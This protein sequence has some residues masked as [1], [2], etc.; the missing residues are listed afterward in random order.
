MHF[1]GL[2][3]KDSRYAAPQAESLSR[4]SRS[5]GELMFWATGGLPAFLPAFL[6]AQYRRYPTEQSF[7][8]ITYT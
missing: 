4:H 5:E 2:F 8:R 1:S 7:G 3:W 6:P